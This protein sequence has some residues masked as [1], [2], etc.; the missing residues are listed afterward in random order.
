MA[1]NSALLSRLLISERSSLLR[2]AQRILGNF[3]AAEDVIQSAWFKIQRVEDYPPIHNP[4]AY[5]YRLASN[6]ALDHMR[7]ARRRA[8]D[9]E[10]ED[11]LWYEDDTPSPENQ[12]FSRLEYER[13]MAAEALLPE[14]TR[15]MFRLNRFEGVTQREIAKRFG[16]SPTIVERH[17]RR[18]LLAL[19]RARNGE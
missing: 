9:T 8:V 3:S 15:E 6:L 10:I 19:D 12:T 7:A 4:R 14:P 1:A 16:V 2:L 17:I 11:I 13:V 5:L 18:A